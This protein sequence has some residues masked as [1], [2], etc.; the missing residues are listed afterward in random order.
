MSKLLKINLNLFE[1][2]PCQISCFYIISVCVRH[3]GLD[4]GSGFYERDPDIR[5]ED[6]EYSYKA[7]IRQ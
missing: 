5:Q 4:P 1:I 2:I 6:F 3:F 7:F